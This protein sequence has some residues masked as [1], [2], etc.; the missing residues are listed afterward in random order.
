MTIL[1][2]HMYDNRPVFLAVYA[3][4]GVENLAKI[5]KVSIS[6]VHK[7]LYQYRQ[8]PIKHVPRLSRK[9]KIPMSKLRPDLFKGEG[10]KEEEKGGL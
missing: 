6:A 9:L 5:C 8:I 4:D 3:A 1:N 7:W 2:E 10:E